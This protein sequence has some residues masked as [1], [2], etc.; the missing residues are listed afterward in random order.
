MSAAGPG[1]AELFSALPVATLV[2]DPAGKIAH[3]NAASETLLNFS[4]R[5]MIGQDVDLLV[6]Y[7]SSWAERRGGRT[8]AA[9]DADV[10]IG[11]IGRARVD[12]IECD[13]PDRSGWTIVTLR[14]HPR[15]H[16]PDRSGGARA[17]I[18]AAAMLAHEI[19]NPLSGIRGAAQLLSEG[20]DDAAELTGLITSE[21]DRVAALIDRMQDFTDTRPPRLSAE[22]VYP[23]L[24]HARR[25]AEAGFARG[26]PIEE[27]FDPSLPPAMIDRDAFT[28]IVINL[29]K[30]ACEALAGV[31]DG[32]VV[33]ATAYRHG[34]SASPGQGRPRRPLPI[35]LSVIDTGPGAPADIADHLFEPF[36]SGKAEGQGLGLPL[37]DKLVRDMGG[38]VTYS[39]EGEPPVTV[40][41][42]LLPRAA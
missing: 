26:V 19:K 25:I 7:P 31:P 18:G 29:L 17:A 1:F 9:Y 13:V 12:L 15:G 42:L 4:E 14:Q 28:Q 21:V 11:R 2:V 41:R 36:V 37:V 40:F 34:M 3:A 39:R 10:G 16:A 33:L 35:E 30:N 5:A 27:R 6:R 8:F 23:L 24:G 20:L 22:N 32:R 38:L